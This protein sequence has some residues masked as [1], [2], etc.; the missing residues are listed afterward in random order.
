M[1]P[2][3]TDA[4]K[5]E[6]RVAILDGA[7]YCFAD[8]GYQ[9]TTVDDIVQHLGISKGAI[10]NYFNS[11]EDM[12]I[13]LMEE[14]VV[15]LMKELGSEFSKLDKATD[16]LMLLFRKFIEQPMEELHRLLSL[17]LEFWLNSSR[18]QDLHSVMVKH[19]DAALNFLCDIIRE[20]KASGEFRE[21][22]DERTAAALF[23][24][25][26]DGLALQFVGN[27]DELEY[28]KHLQGMQDMLLCY[29]VK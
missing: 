25:A 11:K 4:Y 26:R 18:Q 3:V 22:V 2:K 13:Q 21:E 24:A 7:L 27:S 20:G 6:R 28:R 29:L 12:Y 8:K 19:T 9:A 17:Y 16:K 14:R 5:E 23:W 1:S 15:L 10:Y